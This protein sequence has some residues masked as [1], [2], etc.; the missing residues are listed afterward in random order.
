MKSIVYD[1]VSRTRDKILAAATAT[2]LFYL[3][4]LL[5]VTFSVLYILT[6]ETETFSVFFYLKLPNKYFLRVW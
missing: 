2:R 5:G 4:N 6:A 3:N 1:E